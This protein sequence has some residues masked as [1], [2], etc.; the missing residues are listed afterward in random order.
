MRVLLG[1]GVVEKESDTGGEE[2]G[3]GEGRARR[4]RS[5]REVER[6]GELAR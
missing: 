6:E 5:A 1:L 4:V 3:G 2:L